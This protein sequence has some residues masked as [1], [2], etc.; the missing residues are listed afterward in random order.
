M[1]KNQIKNMLVDV[2]K[3]TAVEL[4]VYIV[5]WLVDFKFK[6]LKEVDGYEKKE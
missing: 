3:A 5:D 6:L 1:L 2:I 4:L